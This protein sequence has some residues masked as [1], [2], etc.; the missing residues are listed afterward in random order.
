MR[1]I[2]VANAKGGVAKT[3]TAV[4][5]GAALAK[6]DKRVLLVDTDS[7]GHCGTMLGVDSTDG[8]AA[9]LLGETDLPNVVIEA[10]ENLWLLPGSHALTKANQD[11]AR[12]DFQPERVLAKALE[13]AGPKFHF[14]IFDCAPGWSPLLVNA[15]VAANEVL[16]P[17]SMEALAVDGLGSFLKATEP[18][19]E[20][21]GLEI[22]HVLPTFYDLRVKKSKQLLKQLEQAFDGRLCQPIRYSVRLSEAPAWRQLVWEYEPGDR[23]GDDYRAL[24]RRMINE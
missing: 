21:T 4:H 12:R 5:L 19:R 24:A 7:Q 13:P 9:L 17:V 22:R 8:L 10:R 6:K 23:A 14:C 1:N 3:T 2:A 11:I 20:A 16:S 15:L 18:I